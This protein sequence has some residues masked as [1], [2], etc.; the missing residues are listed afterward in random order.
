MLNHEWVVAGVLV[1]IL[2]SGLRLPRR[3]PRTGQ[4]AGNKN[5]GKLS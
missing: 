2:S 3:R 1:T 4:A 5:R